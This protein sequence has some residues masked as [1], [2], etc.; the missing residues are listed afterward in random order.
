LNYSTCVDATPITEECETTYSQT[1]ECA[2]SCEIY[3]NECMYMMGIM[4]PCQDL[5]EEEECE[6]EYECKWTID[7]NYDYEGCSVE[8][9]KVENKNLVNVSYDVC[10]STGL[11]WGTYGCYEDLCAIYYC[12]YTYF[13]S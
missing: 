7:R 10:L 8:W 4:Y 1:G 9:E 12:E 6:E 13:L 11:T 3:D 5:E 2:S